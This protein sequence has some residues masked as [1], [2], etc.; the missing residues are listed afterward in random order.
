MKS[1]KGFFGSMFG[2][3]RQKDDS[4]AERPVESHSSAEVPS[5]R[6]K[7]EV[8]NRI[9]G[10]YEV[11]QILGGEGKS[12]MGAVYVCYHHEHRTV[13][14]LKTFQDKYLSSDEMKKSFK[15]EALAWTHLERHPYI[16]R[17]IGV[18]ELDNRLYIVLEFIAPDD[19]GRNTLTHYLQ[20]PISL[21]QALEWSIQFCYGMEHAV[22]RGVSPHQD[23][24]P[25]NIMIRRDGTV[26]ITDFGLAKLWDQAET[27]ADW[28]EMAEGTPPGLSF[29]RVSDGKAVVGTLPW[30]SPEQFEGNADIR[31]DI[32]SFGI[33]LYQMANRGKLPFSAQTV[34]GYYQAHKN[35]PVPRFNTKLFP[36]IEQCL[37]KS[38]DARYRDFEELRKD[39]EKLYRAETGEAPPPIPEGPILEAEEHFNKGV[40]FRNLGLLDDAIKEYREAVQIKPDYAGAHYNLGIVLKDKGLFNDAI[41]EY[42]EAL[43]IKT[44]FSEAHYGLGV[45]LKDK[46]LLDDVIEE[47]REALRIKTDF[48]EAHIGLGS[49]LRDKGLID[50][51][52]EEF[53]ET[54]RIK[55]GYAEAHYSLGVVLVDKG[56]FDDAIEEYREALRI[57]SHY[58]EAHYNLGIVLKDKGLLDDAIHEY[59]EALRIKPDLAETHSGLGS[60]LKDKDLL[61]DALKEYREALKIKTDYAEAHYNFG[62]AL[63]DKGLIDDALKE[64]REALRI[65][66]DFVE[67]HLGMGVAFKDKGLFDDA[68]EEFREALRIKSHYA[69]AHYNL[70]IVLY[71]DK[72]LFNDGI[73]EYREAVRI[74]PDYA[75]AHANLGI[76]FYDKS[77]LDDAIQECREALR[78]KPD[79]TEVH[80]ILGA[81]LYAKGLFDEAI[82]AFQIFIK[83]APPQYP[84]EV[85]EQ[86]R[87]LIREMEGGRR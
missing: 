5:S 9:G 82:E 31:S 53:R 35:T 55:P 33:V 69:E 81:A 46:G 76:A 12:G 57:K 44:D 48:S 60:A 15:R 18:V 38:P 84:Q 16:V 67:A 39:L 43:R 68:I 85:V 79:Y 45:V 70:G 28:R 73:E 14:A 37:Q 75:E 63:K 32:Y 27:I 50:D 17:A 22:S 51:A 87:Q 2:G 36:V 34:E 1:V 25:D 52:I 30:M 40:S 23:I 3:S 11:Y 77:L 64:Y 6:G 61:D 54:V 24:K 4:P 72:G 74:K 86:A 65:K 49:A 21:R 62:I 47:Y 10:D 83:Y 29:L 13:Y 58:A 26:K 71:H 20:S 59:R 41:Q 56:L 19:G 78:I 8:G 66:P 42:R 7:I 80:Y